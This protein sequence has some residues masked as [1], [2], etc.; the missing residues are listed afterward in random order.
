MPRGRHWSRGCKILQTISCGYA[1]ESAGNLLLSRKGSRSLEIDVWEAVGR[2]YSAN[3]RC[4]L[5]SL[6]LLLHKVGHI[7]VL[8]VRSH[9]LQTHLILRPPLTIEPPSCSTNGAKESPIQHLLRSGEST[10]TFV[11]W[12]GQ[13]GLLDRES[14]SASR[15]RRAPSSTASWCWDAKPCASLGEI[16]RPI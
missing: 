6:E 3:Q 13:S 1:M 14:F 9:D 12:E 16:S 4:C 2:P 15:T 7:P 5:I 8:P 11:L 10:A